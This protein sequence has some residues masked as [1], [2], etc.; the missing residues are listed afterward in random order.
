MS[1]KAPADVPGLWRHRPLI[2]HND[3][4]SR[5]GPRK[6]PW[7]SRWPLAAQLVSLA[8]G[9]V[10]QICLTRRTVQVPKGPPKGHETMDG[11]PENRCGHWGVAFPGVPFSLARPAHLTVSADHTP[12]QQA[13]EKVWA[14]MVAQTVGRR[15]QD[16]LVR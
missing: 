3:L 8:I 6:P 7:L 12:A 13:K 10:P 4:L 11:Q 9:S 14:E 16:M 1:K 15:R 2:T 5:P